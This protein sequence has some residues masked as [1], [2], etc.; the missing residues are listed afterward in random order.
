MAKTV[1]L[2]AEMYNSVLRSLR[3]IAKLVADNGK[4]L[5]REFIAD[6]LT[7]NIVCLENAEMT[8]L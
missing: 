2:N 5:D 7:V 4:E 3:S 8:Q 6:M 1:E